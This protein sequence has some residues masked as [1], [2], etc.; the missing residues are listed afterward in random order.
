MVRLLVYQTNSPRRGLTLL[1]L[2]VVLTILIAL[3]GIVVASLPGLLERTQAATAAANV[4]EIDAAIRRG[5]LTNQGTLGNRFD[6]LVSTSTSGQIANYVG[7]S[8]N[9]QVGSLSAREVEA[10]AEIGITQLVPA[11]EVS[12]NVTFDSHLEQEIDLGTE[13]KVCELNSEYAGVAMY[14]LWNIEPNAGLRY[15]VFGLG[16]RC[17]LVGGGAQ[18]VF[19]EAPIHFSED[20][21]SNP[22]KMYSRYL[23]VVEIDNTSE[24]NSKARYVGTAIP[25]Q[26]GLVGINEQLEEHYSGQ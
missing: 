1:E 17:T 12:D 7:G 22:K 6:S 14:R 11:R 2:L 18:A 9:F 3:G 21:A 25:H 23:L 13:G 16:Q 24:L 4:S 10:L 15:L 26:T 5:L 19:K 20:A 8:E